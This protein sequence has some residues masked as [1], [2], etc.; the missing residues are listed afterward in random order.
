M[1][2]K[3]K[4]I[5]S[6]KFNLFLTEEEHRKLKARSALKGITMQKYLIGLL[7]KDE[8]EEREFNSFMK[9]WESASEEEPDEDELKA[10]EKGRKEIEKD[11]L[12]DF[13]EA[14][15]EIESES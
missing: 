10:I 7:H 15:L 5:K 13:E 6:K 9:T 2:I 14:I 3:E 4:K 8:E 12:E 1:A 11:D